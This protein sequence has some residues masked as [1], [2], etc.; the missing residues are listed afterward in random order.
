MWC[1][2]YVP[3][4]YM[5]YMYDSFLTNIGWGN[6]QNNFCSTYLHLIEKSSLLL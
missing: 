1:I 2:I 3:N 5:Q 6:S 4:V